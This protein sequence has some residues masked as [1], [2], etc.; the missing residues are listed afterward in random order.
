[1]DTEFLK[2]FQKYYNRLLVEIDDLYEIYKKR[3]ADRIKI[4][5]AEIDANNTKAMIN[6]MGSYRKEVETLFVEKK[7]CLSE[8]EANR[9]HDEIEKRALEEVMYCLY[10]LGCS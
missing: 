1:M 5:L 7:D 8:D 10:L 3:N 6:A 9:K 4:H 2:V